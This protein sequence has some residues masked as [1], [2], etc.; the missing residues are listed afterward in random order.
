MRKALLTDLTIIGYEIVLEGKDIKLRYRG[1]GDPPENAQALIAE[2]RNCKVEAIAILANQLD[3]SDH[4]KE[5][6][7]WFKNAE[8]P[9]EPFQVGRHKTISDPMKYYV[10]LAYDVEVGPTGSRARYGVLENDLQEL[11]DKVFMSEALVTSL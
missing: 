2:L 10:V 11:M 1:E 8:L 6:I 5:L 3:W 7:K 4:T 9:T